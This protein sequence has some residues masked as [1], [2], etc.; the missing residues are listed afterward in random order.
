MACSISAEFHNLLNLLENATT[1]RQRLL[2]APTILASDTT[3]NQCLLYLN[4]F[5]LDNTQR[6]LF[7]TSRLYALT[8]AGEPTDVIKEVIARQK[9]RLGNVVGL[10]QDYMHNVRADAVDTHVRTIL[11]ESD[12]DEELIRE[13]VTDVTRIV[14]LGCGR[15]YWT[16]VGNDMRQNRQRHGVVDAYGVMLS[17]TL[18][19]LSTNH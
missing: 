17:N 1:A 16:M 18:S 12:V 2:Q 7:C 6:L 15:Q 5:I 3:V 8:E 9:E 19:D 10:Y 11:A 13:L 14:R 4:Q